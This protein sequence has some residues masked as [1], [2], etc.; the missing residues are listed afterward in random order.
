MLALTAPPAVQNRAVI[1][2]EGYPVARLRRGDAPAYGA[3]SNA[4]PAPG[5]APR[6]ANVL[7]F[8]QRVGQRLD[9]DAPDRE[10]SPGGW[11]DAARANYP[12]STFLAQHYAQE[13]PREGLAL[14]P[15]ASAAGAYARTDNLSA[16]RG[17]ELVSI[18]V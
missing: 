9:Q 15:Y 7:D 4:P 5:R 18:A 11:R 2:A 10:S 3:P 13:Q 8:A 16:L 14:D 1:D 17:A 12:V 6:S